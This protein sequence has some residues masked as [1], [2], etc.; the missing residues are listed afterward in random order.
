MRFGCGVGVKIGIMI[1]FEEFG[2]KM[3]FEVLK[4]LLKKI[5]LKIL[6]TEIFHT[7]IKV[8]TF[9]LQSLLI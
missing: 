3:S 5:F 2:S 9:H 7:Q 1:L 6:R 4:K 8:H